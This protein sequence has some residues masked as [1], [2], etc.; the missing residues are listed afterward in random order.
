MLAVSPA[1]TNSMENEMNNIVYLGGKGVLVRP[2]AMESVG[3]TNGQNI[4]QDQFRSVVTFHLQEARVALAKKTTDTI[5]E[6][7]LNA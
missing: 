3:L 6:K 7:M 2:G 5:I 4:T 1:M